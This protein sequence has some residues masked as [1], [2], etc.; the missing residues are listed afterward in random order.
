VQRLLCDRGYTGKPFA[1]GVRDIL[2]RRVSVQIAKRSE[3][4]TFKVMPKRWVV[5]RSFAWIDKNRGYGRTVNDCSTPVCNLFILHSSL[6]CSKDFE[7][8][9]MGLLENILGTVLGNSGDNSKQQAIFQAAL[10]MVNQHGGIEGLQ[11]R[12]ANSDLGH[13][14]SSWVS[15]GQNKPISPDQVTQALGHDNVQQIA[16]QAGMSHSDAASCLTQILPAIIDKL[17]PNGSAPAGNTLQQDLSALLNGG[18][19]NLLGGANAP[20]QPQQNQP[21]T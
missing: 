2:G 21:N 5:E 3:L 13:I 1:Q 15:T 7:Q 10:Q 11:Q 18:L 8:T 17:T 12:F 4:R 19:A 20:Q 9:L 6:C 16:Q 14:F